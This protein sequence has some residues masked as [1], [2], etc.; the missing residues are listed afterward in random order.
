VGFSDSN[1]SASTNLQIARR[2]ATAVRDAVIAVAETADL[3]RIAL[4]TEAFGEAMPMAC[5]DT[6]WGRKTNR[7]VEVWVR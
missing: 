1:G 7:R 3:S 5:D 6:A 4:E 2:R